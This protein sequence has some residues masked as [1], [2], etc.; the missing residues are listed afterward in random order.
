MEL[1]EAEAWQR[2]AEIAENTP[3]AFVLVGTGRSMQPLYRPGTILVLRQ[4]A[5]TDLKR[6]QTALYRSKDRHVVAHVLV[7]KARDGWRARG[8]NNRIHD[9]EPVQA[10][11]LVG[12]V[13]AAFQPVGRSRSVSLA[14]IS[15]VKPPALN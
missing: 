8:L 4:L 9:M 3:G 7:A 1:A 11:N 10:D 13:V 15:P 12:V 5:F 14:L 2:A 6:G